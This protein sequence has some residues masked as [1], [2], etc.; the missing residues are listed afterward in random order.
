MKFFNR[1]KSALSEG[2]NI[3]FI[4]E[5]MNFEKALVETLFA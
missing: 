3:N 1:I 5:E 2:V 4:N